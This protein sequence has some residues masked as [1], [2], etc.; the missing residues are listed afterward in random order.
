MT[1]QAVVTRTLGTTRV[2]HRQLPFQA[3]CG[4]ADQRLAC[5]DTRGID[6]FTGGKI[7]RT[8]EHQIDRLH[9]CAQ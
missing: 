2:E 1:V 7:I 6:R 4:T 9:R 8:V 5:G 3:D